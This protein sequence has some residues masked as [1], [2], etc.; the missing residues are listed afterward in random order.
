MPL[1]RH[2]SYSSR[3]L[4]TKK[5]NSALGVLFQKSRKIANINGKKQKLK[6]KTNYWRAVSQMSPRSVSKKPALCR[7]DLNFHEIL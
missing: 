7:P 1:K 2:Q 3:T 5:K 4:K 6:K